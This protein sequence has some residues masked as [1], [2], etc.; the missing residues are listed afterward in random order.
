MPR[1]NILRG[2]HRLLLV[3]WAAWAL[4]V[5]GYVTWLWWTD[6]WRWDRHSTV[7]SASKDTGEEA[8]ILIPCGP[9]TKPCPPNDSKEMNELMN[10]DKARVRAVCCWKPWSYPRYA[11]WRTFAMLIG[12]P[13]VAYVSALPLCQDE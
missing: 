2:L 5:I 3:L 7:V 9:A 6:P 10:G 1:V 8:D 11:F 13:T 4:T 12:W